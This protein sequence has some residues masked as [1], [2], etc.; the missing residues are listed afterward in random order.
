MNH[1]PPGHD[2]PDDLDDLYRRASGL[3][4]SRPSESVRQAVLHHAARLAAQTDSRQFARHRSW[5]RPAAFGTLAAAALAGLLIVPRFLT[6]PTPLTARAPIQRPQPRNAAPAATLA[7]DDR[8]GE[9]TPPSPAPALSTAPPASPALTLAPPSSAPKLAAAQVAPATPAGRLVEPNDQIV[10]GARSDAS[11]E[12]GAEARS[13]AATARARGVPSVR[14]ADEA[15]RRAAQIGDIPGLQAS[16]DQRVA[17][18]A[19]D[20][21]GR[22]ALLLATLHGQTLAVEALLAHGADPNAAD[23]DGTTPLQAAMAGDHPAIVAAL[24]SAGAQ[25]RTMRQTH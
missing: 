20:S 11:S 24:R 12:A 17:V 4:P 7:P 1:V 18:D 8:P 21:S 22:T 19:R 6:P 14:D 15:L 25:P 16:F 23:A 3:D 5:W 13:A 9:P 10:G 2:P